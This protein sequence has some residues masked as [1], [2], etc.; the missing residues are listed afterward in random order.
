MD[1]IF[2]P[3]CGR[4]LYSDQYTEIDAVFVRGFRGRAWRGT[5]GYCFAPMHVRPVFQAFP[6]MQ[7]IQHKHV[8]AQI[9]EALA[10]EGGTARQIAERLGIARSG[11]ITSQ[12]K[13]LTDQGQLRRS[14]VKAEDL[15]GVMPDQIWYYERTD[16]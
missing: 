7:R 11:V 4:E 1:Q 10:V 12:L 16:V 3:N 14:L 9:L 6:G 2:C 8:K 13:Q 15:G 5:C